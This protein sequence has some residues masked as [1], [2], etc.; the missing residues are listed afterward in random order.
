M[1]TAMRVA[2]QQAEINAKWGDRPM[3]EV[4]TARRVQ[5]QRTEL[6]PTLNMVFDPAQPELGEVWK[7]PLREDF[8]KHRDSGAL[9]EVPA[10]QLG[11]GEPSQRE[12]IRWMFDFKVKRNK[13]GDIIRYKVRFN[14]RGDDEIRA[15]KFPDRTELYAP[16]VKAYNLRHF[17]ANAAFHGMEL[18]LMDVTQAFGHTPWNRPTSLYVKVPKYV[19]CDDYAAQ[20]AQAQTDGVHFD[21]MV[22]FQLGAMMHGLADAAHAW[23]QVIN[24]V[25]VDHAGMTRSKGER[26]I[27]TWF[28]EDS[29]SAYLIALTTDDSLEATA[30]TAASQ[31]KRDEVRA[32]LQAVAPITI[33]AQPKKAVGLILCYNLDLSIGVTATVQIQ[34][35]IDLVFGQRERAYPRRGYQCARTGMVNGM[36]RE[37]HSTSTYI[38][39]R[40]ALGRGSH[41]RESMSRAHSPDSHPKLTSAPTTTGRT[42]PTSP[43]TFTQPRTYSWCIT[44]EATVPKSPM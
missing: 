27:Y 21:E 34:E 42:S 20:R 24:E 37:P 35:L 10:E 14:L 4:C 9:I 12:Y 1:A 23:N 30:P 38:V 41:G 39:K 2:R 28:G 33:D 29:E 19:I 17:I 40:R 31:K 7:P 36:I 6:N 22:H 43:R 5:V 25:L 18:S 3:A 13:N 11:R 8:Q 44:A 32:A 16:N 15:G 26:C